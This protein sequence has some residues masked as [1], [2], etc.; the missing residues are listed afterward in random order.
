MGVCVEGEGFNVCTIR[1]PTATLSST[2]YCETE[3]LTRLL[4]HEFANTHAHTHTH[5]WPL[6]YIEAYCNY[7]GRNAFPSHW[8]LIVTRQQLLPRCEVFCADSLPRQCSVAQVV[9]RQFAC[10]QVSERWRERGEGREEGRGGGRERWRD[11]LQFRP[12]DGGKVGET[13]S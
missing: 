9:L 10:K 7:T 1:V 3:L 8:H 11:N 2:H 12:F 13:D 6:W 4:L 5:H